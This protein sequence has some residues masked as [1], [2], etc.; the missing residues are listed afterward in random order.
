MQLRG[1]RAAA[2]PTRTPSSPPCSSSRKRAQSRRCCDPFSPPLRRRKRPG[3]LSRSLQCLKALVGWPRRRRGGLRWQPRSRARPSQYAIETTLQLGGGTALEC[4]LALLVESRADVPRVRPGRSVPLGHSTTVPQPRHLFGNGSILRLK[5]VK[6][7]S[8]VP[9]A[10]P[11]GWRCRYGPGAS[12]PDW[13]AL[14]VVGDAATLLRPEKESMV[15]LAEKIAHTLDGA[16]VQAPVN[17]Q[18]DPSPDALSKGRGP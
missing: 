7:A 17:V 18:R 15:G 16:G 1:G 5:L 12:L 13:S 2:C 8:N 10:C 3:D 9:Q 14:V 11:G 6:D 4:L